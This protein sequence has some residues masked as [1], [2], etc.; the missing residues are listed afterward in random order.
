MAL[1]IGGRRFYAFDVTSINEIELVDR[2]RAGD[3]TAFTTL[4]RSHHPGMVRLARGYVPNRAVA[5][6]VAQE[7]WLGLLRGVDKFEGRSS[8]KT[9]LYRIV[10]NRARSAGVRERREIPL[11]LSA[12]GQ[13][14]DRFA[15]D[16]AWANPPVP[17]TDQIDERLTAASLSEQI[18]ACLD[19]LPHNQREV[20]T[21]RDIDGLSAAETCEVL[22]ITEANQRVLLHRG[23]ARLRM[24]LDSAM[25]QD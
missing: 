14:V 23:R 24:H 4:V 8:L 1:V 17:W 18:H 22:G 25:R 5:E 9:W 16:G 12:S 6:E 19:T 7:A 15:P 20:I 10:V 11:D 13:A 3:E 2:L 21:L